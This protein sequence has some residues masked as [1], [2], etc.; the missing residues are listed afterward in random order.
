MCGN[1]S[2]Y[3]GGDSGGLAGVADEISA[4]LLEGLAG[5]APDGLAEACGAGSGTVGPEVA[6][7]RWVEI[8][9]GPGFVG[10]VGAELVFLVRVVG[11]GSGST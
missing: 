10:L 6:T 2:E 5:V 1:N 4:V 3:D 7:A 8:G 11:A 9:A